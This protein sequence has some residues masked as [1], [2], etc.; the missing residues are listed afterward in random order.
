MTSKA[1]RRSASKKPSET[2]CEKLGITPLMRAARKGEMGSQ[3]PVEHLKL[4][5]RTRNCLKKAHVT[6]VAQVLEMSDGEL[7]QIPN[8][9][10]RSLTE[11]K[12]LLK[13]LIYG[14]E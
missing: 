11:L 1:N 10:E 7:L 9:G 8:F 14:D 12:N 5:P 13:R 3:A 4:S 6:K 2:A